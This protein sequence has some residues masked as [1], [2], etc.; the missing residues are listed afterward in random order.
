MY[1]KFTVNYRERSYPAR[2][3]RFFSGRSGRFFVG[4]IIKLLSRARCSPTSTRYVHVPL[5]TFLPAKRPRVRYSGFTIL[6]HT[7]IGAER[8][9]RPGFRAAVDRLR[10]RKNRC[11]CAESPSPSCPVSTER[12]SYYRVLLPGCILAI[13][14]VHNHLIWYNAP[15][16]LFI[17]SGRRRRRRRCC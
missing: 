10:P 8:F 14:Y 12:T 6:R 9:I 11:R 4:S 15:M 5:G 17:R 1:A 7:G 3:C 16:G 13:R 2:E